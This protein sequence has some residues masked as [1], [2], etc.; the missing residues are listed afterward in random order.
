MYRWIVLPNAIIQSRVVEKKA[1][2]TIMYEALDAN[3]IVP[4][5]K[6]AMTI[7]DAIKKWKQENKE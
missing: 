6:L 5:G 3:V 4:G 2:G 1:N 7:D